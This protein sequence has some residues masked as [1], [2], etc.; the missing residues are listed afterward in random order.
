MAVIRGKPRVVLTPDGVDPNEAPSGYIAMK[1]NEDCDYTDK[2]GQ[3]MNC[4][5][6]GKG[7]CQGPSYMRCI[8]EFRTDKQVV[9]FKRISQ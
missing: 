6:Y 9:A 4:C 5:F 2:D 1:G 7:T 8:S 3:R